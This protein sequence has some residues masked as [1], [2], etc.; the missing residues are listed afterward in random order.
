MSKILFLLLLIISLQLYASNDHFIATIENPHV[1]F[2]LKYIKQSRDEEGIY[3]LY[4]MNAQ[5]IS[6]YA[7][8][9]VFFEDEA[10][11]I[12]INDHDKNE[13]YEAIHFIQ[14][15]PLEGGVDHSQTF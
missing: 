5:L 7:E 11:I 12:I 6:T 13:G 4:A 15:T 3:R 2:F 8:F 10:G 1:P 14:Y 9:D